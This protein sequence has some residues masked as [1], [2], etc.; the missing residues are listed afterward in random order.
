[1]S[2]VAILACSNAGLDYLD[3]PKDII[4]LRS[5]VH[6]G[7]DESYDDFVDMDA[8]TFYERI[9]KNPND[10]PKTSFVTIGKMIEYVV[11]PH[12]MWLFVSKVKRIEMNSSKMK[13]NNITLNIILLLEETLTI[14]ENNSMW[15]IV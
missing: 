8:K 1:M 3:Y 12:C 14:L 7:A 6:F 9:A 2:K 11:E 13:S 15:F 5:A 10:I 4:I